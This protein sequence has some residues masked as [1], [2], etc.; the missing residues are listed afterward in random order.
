MGLVIKVRE[1]IGRCHIYNMGGKIVIEDGCRVNLKK[2]TAICMHSLAAIMPYYVALSKVV[3]PVELGLVRDG[4]KAYVQCLDP[5]KYT[6]GGTV[7]FEISRS[8]S[9]NLD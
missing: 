3:S 8:T 9:K 6:G 7:I 5:C 1:I 4:N 2:T